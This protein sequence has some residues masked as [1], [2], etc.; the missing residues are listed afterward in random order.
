M[1]QIITTTVF[2]ISKVEQP[3]DV[4]QLRPIACCNVL[5]KI[6]SKILCNWLKVV[7]P[8]LVDQV[9]S[10][11]V[12]N[13][14]ITHNILICK[15]I[16]NHYKRKSEPPRCT[17]K[18]NLMKAYNSVSWGFLGELLMKMHFPDQFRGWI[19]TCVTSPAF[20]ISINGGLCGFFKGKKGLR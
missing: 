14:I 9:R 18:I 11:F 17:T 5:Y 16:L 6:I 8:C 1:K 20:S 19:M 12:E 3:E 7:L 13:M 2:L 15:D 10:E 4:S